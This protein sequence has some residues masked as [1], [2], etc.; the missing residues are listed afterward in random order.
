MEANRWHKQGVNEFEVGE[1]LGGK[2]DIREKVF[3]TVLG[4]HCGGMRQ[5]MEFSCSFSFL[6]AVTKKMQQQT[7]EKEKFI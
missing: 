5:I 4:L 7:V 3:T 2:L 6:T 1:I